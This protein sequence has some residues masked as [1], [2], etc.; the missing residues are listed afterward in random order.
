MTE[1]LMLV[2]PRTATSRSEAIIAAAEEL[3]AFLRGRVANPSGWNP[4]DCKIAEQAIVWADELA[5][6]ER[7][8]AVEAGARDPQ[9]PDYE[10]D[11]GQEIY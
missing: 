4:K 8:L 3:A 7:E 5:N 9:D 1:P 2:E 10:G 6:H 11:D